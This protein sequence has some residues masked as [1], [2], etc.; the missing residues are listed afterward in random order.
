MISE[1]TFL[2]LPFI[3]LWGLWLRF[4][5]KIITE[6][7]A[8]PGNDYK[9]KRIKIKPNS[10]VTLEVKGKCA[11]LVNSMS[12]WATIRINNGVKQK[13]YKI[14]L[15]NADGKLEIINESK[16]FPLDIIVRCSYVSYE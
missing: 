6:G 11:I 1:I 2:L 14:R 12:G 10:S 4:Y 7:L 13:I 3:I 8:F 15:I 16:I 5:R 9:E